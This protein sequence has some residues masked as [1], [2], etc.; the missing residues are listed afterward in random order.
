MQSK[1]VCGDL[2]R[3]LANDQVPLSLPSLVQVSS[4]PVTSSN[5]QVSS[6]SSAAMEVEHFQLPT[7]AAKPKK[8]TKSKSK[9]LTSGVSQKAPVVKEVSD[10]GRC[11]HQRSP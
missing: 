2:M 9:K 7:Q 4:I 5:P 3:I 10:E 6:T 11:E 8:L 1:R